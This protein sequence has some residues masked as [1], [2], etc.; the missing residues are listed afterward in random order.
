MLRNEA[1]CWQH[2]ASHDYDKWA[3]QAAV[4]YFL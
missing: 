4:Q 2:R 1:V 3:T